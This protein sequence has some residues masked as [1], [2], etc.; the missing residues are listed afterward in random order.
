MDQRGGMMNKE[1]LTGKEKV[2]LLQG[3]REAIRAKL[4]RRT[5]VF[6]DGFSSVTYTYGAFV[7]L[8][9]HGNLR[10]CIGHM[11]GDA[12]LHATIAE[13]A[14][15]AAFEDPRF[16]PLRVQEFSDCDIEISVLSPM[17]PCKPADII[18]GT[19]GAYLICA[20]RAGVF[21][22]QVATE[23]GWERETF[24]EHLCYKAGLP[25]GS[26]ERSDAR[27]FSFTAIVFGEKEYKLIP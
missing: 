23:Q 20:G 15:A 18:P 9:K 8:H 3:A 13:M 24:L 12:P 2:L 4:E 22:P 19:H 1:L 5:P 10:G 25:A 21:L 14:V 26:H 16:P 6:P 7:T 17:E 11:T 27:L